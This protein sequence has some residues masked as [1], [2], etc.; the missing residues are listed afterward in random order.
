MQSPVQDQRE[1]LN[2]TPGSS[3]C[4]KLPRL[5]QISSGRV[6]TRRRCCGDAIQRHPYAVALSPQLNTQVRTWRRSIAE[7]RPRRASIHVP[8]CSAS[9]RRAE[10]EMPVRDIAARVLIVWFHALGLGLRE[11]GGRTRLQKRESQHNTSTSFVLHVC[12]SQS[13]FQPTK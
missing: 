2:S 1:V 3:S 10:T 8:R 9:S 6:R 12:A 4:P 7:A 5:G 11:R 13:R